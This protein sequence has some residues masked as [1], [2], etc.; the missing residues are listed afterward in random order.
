MVSKFLKV[1]IFEPLY[2]YFRRNGRRED[3][4]RKNEDL[5]LEAKICN[6]PQFAWSNWTLRYKTVKTRKHYRKYLNFGIWPHFTAILTTVGYCHWHETTWS[7]Y[8]AENDKNTPLILPSL[9]IL[10]MSKKRRFAKKLRRKRR[11]W[12]PIERLIFRRFSQ[13]TEPVYWAVQISLFISQVKP[14][15]LNVGGTLYISQNKMS[16]ATQGLN[17]NNNYAWH[18][19]LVNQRTQILPYLIVV[20]I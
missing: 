8:K 15:V 9:M 7:H 1:Y 18:V 5:K 20:L 11:S 2:G 6:W 19:R 13:T 4:C 17:P 14:V 10:M 16:L 12:V 3:H